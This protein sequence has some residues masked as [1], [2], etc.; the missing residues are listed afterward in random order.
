MRVE[1]KPWVMEERWNRKLRGSCGS[2]SLENG[3]LPCPSIDQV[4]NSGVNE[5][6]LSSFEKTDDCVSGCYS[7]SC[8]LAQKKS[9]ISK[10]QTPN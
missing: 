1:E 8:I 4:A 5:P 3:G 7:Q 6:V 9:S 2:C 10:V